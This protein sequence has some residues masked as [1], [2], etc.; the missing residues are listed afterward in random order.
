VLNTNTNTNSNLFYHPL[1][2]TT[3]TATT[4]ITTIQS[5]PNNNDSKPTPSRMVNNHVAPSNDEVHPMTQPNDVMHVNYNDDYQ[6]IKR[7]LRILETL[8]KLQEDLVLLTR[9]DV[10]LP[11]S[12]DYTQQMEQVFHEYSQSLN[13]IFSSSASTTSTTLCD[14]NNRKQ[15]H[16]EAMGST[17]TSRSCRSLSNTENSVDAVIPDTLTNFLSTDGVDNTRLH[18]NDSIDLHII[19]VIERVIR[20]IDQIQLNKSS[21]SQSPSILQD[22]QE[23]TFSI[24]YLQDMVR[25]RIILF[26]FF[27]LQEFYLLMFQ[28]E[29][30]LIF[31]A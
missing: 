22:A 24:Q 29:L 30:C 5:D 16:K 27:L 19:S 15:V 14:R 10:E 17:S 18:E 8:S 28:V 1:T 31:F 11:S 2:T 9:H 3:T 4:T 12:N 7:L 23:L 25:L 13:L 26:T 21:L 6:S 20:H